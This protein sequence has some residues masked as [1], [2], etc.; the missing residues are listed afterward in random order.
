GFPGKTPYWTSSAKQAVGASLGRQSTV[1]FT[2]HHGIVTEVFFPRA[3]QPAVARMELIVSDRHGFYSEESR[4]AEHAIEW[5]DEGAAIYRL[6]NHCRQGRYRIEKTAFA[7][8]DAAALVQR[9]RFVPSAGRREDYRVHVLLHSH[10]GNHGWRNHGWTGDFGG[11]PLL[12]AREDDHCAALGASVRWKKLSVGYAGVSDGRRQ[13]RKYGRLVQTYRYAPRGN[14]GLA[15]ELDLDGGGE[16][17]LALGFGNAP[18][19]AATRTRQTIFADADALQRRVAEQ[20]KTWQARLQDFESPPGAAR[21]LYR[22]STMVLKT[23]EDKTIAGAFVASLSIPWGAARKTNGGFGPVGY[24]VVWPRDLY[25]VAGGLLAA[26][27]GDSA[28]R[29]LEYCQA[30][31]KANGGWTQNQAVNGAARWTGRQLGET[32]LPVLLFDL[33]NRADLLSAGDRRRYWPMVRRALGRIVRQGPSAQEDRWEDARGF[34]PF[35]LSDMIAALVVGSQLAHE[36]GDETLA[37]VFLETA[38]AWH[39]SIDYWTYVEDTPLARRI[40]VSGYYLRVAPPDRRGSPMKYRGEFEFWYRRWPQNEL[41]PEDVVSVDALAFVRFGLRAPDDPR[42][43]NTVRVIDAL[44]KTDTPM[45]PVWR[46]YNHDGYGEKRDGSPFDGES[47]IGRSWPLLTGERAHY[48]LLAGRPNEAERL[49]AAMERFAGDGKMLPE[50]IWDAADIPSREL[51]FGRPSGSAMPLAW[52]HAEYIK[53]RRSLAEGQV[54]DLPAQTWRRYVLEQAEGRHVIWRTNHQRP[55]LPQGKILRIM[56]DAPATLEWQAGRRGCGGRAS[57]A[58]AGE[59]IH[60]I[61]L[62]TEDLPP[63]SLIRFQF[64]FVH[65]KRSDKDEWF[66]ARSGEMRVC[67]EPRVPRRTAPGEALRLKRT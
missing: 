34:T 10:L 52:A 17:V 30:T 33:A 43:L 55:T 50:Q 23:H 39:D 27:D 47:G 32:S 40:G 51:F 6:T 66:V 9:V 29:A 25:M 64:E 54:F 48:E 56:L 38:D 41:P 4:D 37:R 65:A 45:G 3:D 28:L 60:Y 57:T 49:L 62:P 21:D 26:G 19:E 63:G 61:D 31:Q 53:L 1:W 12:F 46:R 15:A 8:P 36:Q 42:I 7:H 14:I 18:E 59:E 16:F 20:W 11:Q 24:H 35:S 58:N 67:E 2:L 22:A 13:L 5:V 44:L